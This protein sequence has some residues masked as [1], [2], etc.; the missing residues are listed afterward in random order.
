MDS[1]NW[2]QRNIKLL[3]EIQGWCATALQQNILDIQGGWE[4]WR[5]N[6]RI[7]SQSGFVPLDN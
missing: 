2:L 5:M 1:D 3:R 4:N 7:K 6:N